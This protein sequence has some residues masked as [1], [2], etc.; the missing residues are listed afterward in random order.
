MPMFKFA[1]ITLLIMIIYNLVMGFVY[2]L[3]DK[4]T[5]NRGLASL[6]TRIVLSVLL[7]ALLIVG[8]YMDMIKPNSF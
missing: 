4:S 2:I 3:K 5:S 1:I 7:F 8:Y 6:K